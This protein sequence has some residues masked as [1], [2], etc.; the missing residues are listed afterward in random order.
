MHR[1][2]QEETQ[3]TEEALKECNVTRIEARP[4]RELNFN[5]R[6]AEDEGRCAD[7]LSEH[8]R[9]NQGDHD[10]SRSWDHNQCL[11]VECSFRQ[12]ARS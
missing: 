9:H 10:L 2:S 3:R 11:P 12:T 7:T 6:T 8:D 5:R 4:T 1:G